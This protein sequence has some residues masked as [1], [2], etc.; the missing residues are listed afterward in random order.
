MELRFRLLWDNSAVGMVSH[1]GRYRSAINR[2]F[3]IYVRLM[4]RS[5]VRLW[6]KKPK[7]TKVHHSPAISWVQN[8]G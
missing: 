5:E 1:S 3:P 8:S 6:A 2:A 7:S 4:S